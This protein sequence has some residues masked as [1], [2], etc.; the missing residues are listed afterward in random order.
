MWEVVKEI[1]SNLLN[2]SYH[3]KKKINKQS[4]IIQQQIKIES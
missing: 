2:N 1:T 3:E 4:S